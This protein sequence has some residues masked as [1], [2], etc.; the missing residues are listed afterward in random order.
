MGVCDPRR[1]AEPRQAPHQARRGGGRE[2]HRRVETAGT[3]PPPPRTAKTRAPAPPA[4]KAAPKARADAEAVATVTLDRRKTR[5]IA[6]GAVEIDA[7]IDLHGMRQDEA[8]HALRSFVKRCHAEDMRM[9]LV[10]TGKGG[11]LASG[12]DGGDLMPMRERGVLRRNV[13][14]WLAEPDHR[15]VHRRH[16]PAHMSATAAT[17]RSTSCC[18]SGVDQQRV[19]YQPRNGSLKISRKPLIVSSVPTIPS[20]PLTPSRKLPPATIA[21]EARTIEIC[22]SA[23]PQSK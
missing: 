4:P 11:A 17:A 3:A 8:H 9:V 12:S 6:K 20:T 14:R 13:P 15:P 22:S 1:R 16:R 19:R 21:T 7:R 23:C 5:R 10:I 18:A 2:P